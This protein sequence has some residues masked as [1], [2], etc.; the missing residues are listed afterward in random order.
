MPSE[1]EILQ[2]I[3]DDIRKWLGITSNTQLIDTLNNINKSMQSILQTNQALLDI[4]MGKPLSTIIT[5]EGKTL[6]YFTSD[7]NSPTIINPNSPFPIIT[8]SGTGTLY[9]IWVVI[10]GHNDF[11]LKLTIDDADFGITP[12]EL[13]TYTTS[14]LSIENDWTWTYLNVNTTPPVFGM[15]WQGKLPI[16]RNLQFAVVN[17]SLNNALTV[18]QYRYAYQMTL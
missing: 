16:N 15:R 4:I 17:N 10:T 9:Y 8:A 12:D 6:A 14:A 13:I 3:R 11:R 5:T 2:S 18:T 7:I 1:L